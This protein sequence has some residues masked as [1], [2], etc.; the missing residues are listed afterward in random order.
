MENLEIFL[1]FIFS[2]HCAKKRKWM[3]CE[4]C[5]QFMKLNSWHHKS[6]IWKMKKKQNKTKKVWKTIFFGATKKTNKMC[7]QIYKHTNITNKE[8]TNK[9]CTF[10]KI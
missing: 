5:T 1:D 4:V 10:K 6:C 8:A 2:E 7:K 9:V 3:Q